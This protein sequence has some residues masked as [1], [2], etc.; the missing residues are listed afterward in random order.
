MEYSKDE[1]LTE[2]KEIS[3]KVGKYLIDGGNNGSCPIDVAKEI[4]SITES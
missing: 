1:K 3:D 2:Y 4:Y